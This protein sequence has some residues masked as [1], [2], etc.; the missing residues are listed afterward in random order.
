MVRSRWIFRERGL[1]YF[2]GFQYEEILV[3]GEVS[4]EVLQLPKAKI[5]DIEHASR[6]V[7]KKPST[8]K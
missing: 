2:E 6:E 3:P 5:S 4:E 1:E 7:G 8:E